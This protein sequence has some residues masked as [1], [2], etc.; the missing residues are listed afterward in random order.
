MQLGHHDHST[1]KT[2]VCSLVAAVSVALGT[3]ILEAS[4]TQTN[5]DNPITGTIVTVDD[6]TIEIDQGKHYGRGRFEVV[7]DTLK[8]KIPTPK[9]GE[10][11]R[12]LWYHCGSARSKEEHH[13]ANKIE[14]LGDA[15]P[16]SKRR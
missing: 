1:V 5:W 12:V 9:V 15:E 2:L 7:W 14:K 4:A 3:A 10:K 6:G 11:V 8:G 13:C 16:G